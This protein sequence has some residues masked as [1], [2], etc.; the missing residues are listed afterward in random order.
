M[1]WPPYWL[2]AA[3]LAAGSSLIAALLAGGNTIF[4]AAS[5]VCTSL[6]TTECPHSSSPPPI[7]STTASTRPAIVAIAS[8]VRLRISGA[9]LHVPGPSARRPHSLLNNQQLRPSPA[10]T[11]GPQGPGSWDLWPSGTRPF[12]L[13]V[14]CKT[15]APGPRSRQDADQCPCLAGRAGGQAR[16]ITHALIKEAS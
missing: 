2:I 16:R 5:W 6:L 12:Y 7:A 1:S 14:T 15:V 4:C 13:V 9:S 8:N 3:A 11:A 10:R